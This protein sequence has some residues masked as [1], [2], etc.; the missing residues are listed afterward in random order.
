MNLIRNWKLIIH[1]L[2]GTKRFGVNN[3]WAEGFDS[4]FTRP[5]FGFGYGIL[6]K[7]WAWKGVYKVIRLRISI[8]GLMSYQKL[9]SPSGRGPHSTLR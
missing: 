7:P 2:L 1:L 3:R 4:I 6:M 8:A 5:M 9:P